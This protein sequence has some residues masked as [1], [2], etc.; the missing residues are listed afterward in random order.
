MRKLLFTLL[1]VCVFFGSVCAQTCDCENLQ[2]QVDTLTMQVQN[3]IDLYEAIDLDMK[4]WSSIV[5]KP[6][7]EPVVFDN[8]TVTLYTMLL[9]TKSR[10]NVLEF[11]M[12][13]ENTSEVDTIDFVTQIRLKAFQDGVSLLEVHNN[14]TARSLRPGHNFDIRKI[15]VLTNVDS[16]VELEFIPIW[17]DADPE[18]RTINIK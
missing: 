5:I 7:L 15:Y 9:K 3:L 8:C 10:Y 18:I 12:T 14:G 16:P 4:D 2:A 11:Y 1:F 17:S 6:E 13:F